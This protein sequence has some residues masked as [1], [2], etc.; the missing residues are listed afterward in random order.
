M[1]EYVLITGGSSGLGLELVKECHARGM[2]VCSLSRDPAKI[3]GMYDMFP[4]RFTAF[5]GDM[6][7]PAYVQ[8]SVDRLFEDGRVSMLINNAERG[9][10][11]A[12]ADYDPEDVEISLQGLRGMELVTT[13]VL[14]ASGEHD[15][16]IVN[17]L[18]SAARTGKPKEA[19]Y[20]AAKW[21]ERGYTE[22]LKAA[23]ADTSVKVVA[24]YPSG[25]NTAFWETSRDYI[26]TE[27]SDT[28][29]DPANV[30]KLILDNVLQDNDLIDDE[31]II[32]RN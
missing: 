26:P 27:K 21:G 30:A 1:K 28:F 29:L 14:R 7:D 25:M 11:K 17:I 23:Y 22:A 15:L 2:Y 18:S 5:P 9:V 16:K 32:K 13:A 24:V 31:Q 10:F 20:C 4:E 3:A 8:E 19:L 12:P 6:T